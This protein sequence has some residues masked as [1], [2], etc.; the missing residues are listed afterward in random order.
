VTLGS[1]LGQGTALFR[2]TSRLKPGKH[3]HQI[4]TASFPTLSNFYSSNTLQFDALDHQTHK[5]AHKE[6]TGRWDTQSSN[7]SELY[8]AFINKTKSGITILWPPGDAHACVYV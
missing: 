4:K 1:I 3:F 8:N 2:C 7:A 6:D 5:T